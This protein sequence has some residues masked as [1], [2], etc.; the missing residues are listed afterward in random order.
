M[1]HLPFSMKHDL[2]CHSTLSSCCKEEACTADA[3]FAQAHQ[4]G[5]DTLCLTNH[6]WDPDVPGAWP[7]YAPQTVE[8]VLSALPL[9]TYPDMR[10]LMG[11]E[12][13]LS[14]DGVLALRRDHFDLFDFVVI[15]PNHM[16]ML[17]FVRPRS[18]DTPAKI[19]EHFMARMELLAGMDLPFEKIGFAHLTTSLMFREG[20][21]L[22]VFGAIEEKRMMPVFE[23]LARAGAGIEL[24]GAAFAKYDEAPEA[25]LRIYRMAKRAGCKF[26][27]S[28]DAHTLAAYARVREVLP[29][30]VEAL[31]L[32]GDDRYVVP[33]RR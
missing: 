6:M 10:T 28:S 26:Y 30:I 27:C 33:E 25:Y 12:I 32:T 22:D 19:A 1:E 7:W 11:C 23:R 4:W 2:H 17:D 16:H 21:V 20:N 18:M 29:P 24:N 8:H 9:P 3:V 31:E 5:Y 15:P 13:E 14:R